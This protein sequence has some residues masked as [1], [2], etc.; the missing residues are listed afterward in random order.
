MGFFL[1][2]ALKSF[3]N[4]NKNDSKIRS[5][6]FNPTALESRDLFCTFEL[7][8]KTIFGEFSIW[9]Y[10]EK[11]P[12][13]PYFPIYLPCWDSISRQKR[14]IDLYGDFSLAL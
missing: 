4:A 5:I 2:V 14:D 3:V 11:V 13:Y 12:P 6:L 7:K 8:K 10:I 1:F 9:D